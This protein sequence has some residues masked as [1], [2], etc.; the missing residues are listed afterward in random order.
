MDLDVFDEVL[1][2]KSIQGDFLL[3]D[4]CNRVHILSLEFK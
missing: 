3:T 2:K 4:K 1:L